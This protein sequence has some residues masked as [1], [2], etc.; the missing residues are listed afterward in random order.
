MKG[1][2]AAADKGQAG[3][4]RRDPPRAASTRGWN[5]IQRPGEGINRRVGNSDRGSPSLWAEGPPPRPSLGPSPVRAAV[6]PPEEKP[7]WGAGKRALCGTR[8]FAAQQWLPARTK[9]RRCSEE[10]VKREK[11][12]ERWRGWVCRDGREPFPQGDGGVC[13]MTSV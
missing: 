1:G 9:V 2:G 6:K 7:Q 13:E 11:T 8:G 12:R 4:E 10:R 3:E 5:F